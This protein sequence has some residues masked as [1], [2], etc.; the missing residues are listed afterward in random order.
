VRIDTNDGFHIRAPPLYRCEWPRSAGTCRFR[1][2]PTLPS[3]HPAL[4][5]G[6]GRHLSNEDATRH[7]EGEP[8]PANLILPAIRKTA[9][10]SR[11]YTEG[12]LTARQSW[13]PIS[14]LERS[15][16][17]AVAGPPAGCPK[18]EG[19]LLIVTNAVGSSAAGS[20]D[21]KIAAIKQ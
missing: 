16:Q 5:I 9:S 12:R 3:S 14:R 1:L 10:R 2:T 15:W 18:L 4:G 19:A 6:R 17:T 7:T 20:P 11:T 8:G 21:G 13:K